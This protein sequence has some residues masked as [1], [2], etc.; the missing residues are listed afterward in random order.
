M[1]NEDIG[2]TKN[3]MEPNPTAQIRVQIGALTSICRK[4]LKEIKKK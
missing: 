4:N 1:T 3:M 2:R